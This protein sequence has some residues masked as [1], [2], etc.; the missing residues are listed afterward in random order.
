MP[1]RVHNC[2]FETRAWKTDFGH[3]R[4][5]QAA[6]R[7]ETP[8]FLRAQVHKGHN[9]WRAGS[10]GVQKPGV[11]FLRSSQITCTAYPPGVS[12]GVSPGHVILSGVET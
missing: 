8:D 5:L 4:I 10:A 3:P 1:Q 6:D 9:V 7:E 2:C 12:C 11:P